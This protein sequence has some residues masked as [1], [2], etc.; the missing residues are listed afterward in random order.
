MRGIAEGAQRAGNRDR[1]RGKVA[2]ADGEDRHQGGAAFGGGRAVRLDVRLACD[3]ANVP[4]AAADAFKA[5]AGSAVR[6]AFGQVQELPAAYAVQP[7]AAP[8]VRRALSRRLGHHSPAGRA[9]RVRRRRGNRQ[10]SDRRGG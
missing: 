9:L 7:E 5:S 3:L 1:E 4:P 2:R 6:W 10:C 8:S